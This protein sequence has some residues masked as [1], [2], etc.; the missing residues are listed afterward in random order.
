MKTVVRR[1]TNVR[2]T[3]HYT[4]A[5]PFKIIWVDP[6]EIEY[7]VAEQFPIVWGEVNSGDWY[8]DGKP[9][10]QTD[11]Y[12]GT[13]EYLETGDSSLLENH[14]KRSYAPWSG[15]DDL[16]FDDWLENF[17]SMVE[18]IEEE[19]YKT[20]LELQR[21]RPN[22]VSQL[23]NEFVAPWL[24]DIVLYIGPETSPSSVRRFSQCFIILMVRELV[25]MA[26][27]AS[28]GY[29]NQ[30]R[31]AFSITETECQDRYSD[32]VLRSTRQDSTEIN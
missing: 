22:Q 20:E 25:T 11:V 28:S 9:F 8:K 30:Q 6:R 27:R 19:G 16:Q 31:Q 18:S 4:D 10:E 3:V 32:A 14:F 1:Y 5:D 29:R 2:S 7:S 26:S 17:D 15:L 12:Q 21:Q 23:N 13:R 24:N